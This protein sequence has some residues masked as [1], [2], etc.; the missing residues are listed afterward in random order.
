MSPITL[1]SLKP[2][3]PE[4]EPDPLEEVKTESIDPTLAANVAMISGGE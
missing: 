4:P 2:L 3:E 1:S